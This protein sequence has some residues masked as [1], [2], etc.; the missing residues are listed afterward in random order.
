MVSMY[1][2]TKTGSIVP[3]T[4][5]HRAEAKVGVMRLKTY[6][7]PDR[8]VHRLILYVQNEPFERIDYEAWHGYGRGPAMRNLITRML[9]GERFDEFTNE[10]LAHAVGGNRILSHETIGWS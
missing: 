7:N 10:D 4:M 6:G 5:K 8:S 9:K 3:C 2:L 1:R